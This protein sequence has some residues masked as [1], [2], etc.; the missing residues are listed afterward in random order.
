MNWFSRL[1]GELQRR[2]VFRVA[3][4][5]MF[6]AWLMMQVAEATF[7]PLR[8]PDWANTLVIVLAILGFPVAIIF[9][10]A[11]EL[12]P[13]G[14]ERDSDGTFRDSESDASLTTVDTNPTAH[15]I[16]QISRNRLLDEIRSCAGVEEPSL[17]LARFDK[18]AESFVDEEG[19]LASR[20]WSHAADGDGMTSPISPRM[21]EASVAVLPFMDSSPKQDYGYFCDGIAEEIINALCTVDDLHVASRTSSFQFRNRV[22]DVREIGKQLSVKSVL[23]GSFRKAGDQIRITAQLIDSETGYHLWSREFDCRIEEVFDVQEEIAR[24][25]TTALKRSLALELNS[26]RRR[27]STRDIAAYDSYLQGRRYLQRF[28]RENLE[29]ALDVFQRATEFDPDYALAYVGLADTYSSLYMG[30]EASEKNRALALEASSRALALAPNLAESYSSLGLA[31]S[32]NEDFAAAEA[33]FEVAIEKN[34]RIYDPYYFYGRVC[35]QQGNKAKAAELFERANQVRPSDYQTPLLLSQIYKDLGQEDKAMESARRGVVAAERTLRLGPQEVRAL[36]LGCGALLM[37]GESVRAQEWADQALALNPED[38]PTL[39]NL[40]CYY[41]NLG[42]TDKALDYLEKA[43][44]SE[45]GMV[46]RQW[47]IHDSDLAVLRDDPRFEAIMN[48][49]DRPLEGVAVLEDGCP[50]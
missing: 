42:F 40:A 29:L 36:Y 6:V 33:I 2:Q 49:A 23:E 1:L 5:Y 44:I 50:D 26:I 3:V 16:G 15:V 32:L 43:N 24:N 39:Y 22:M 13:A 28:D 12:T 48:V 41:A 8:L 18:L 19:Q 20:H 34:P 10:W 35:F 27:A 45:W 4:V 14:V 38:G 9:A 46:G 47:L 17:R 11:F 25:I 7:D 37:L 31:L 21:S 30:F